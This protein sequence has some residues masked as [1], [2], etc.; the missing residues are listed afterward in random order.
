M[1]VAA[2]FGVSPHG[3]WAIGNLD[4]SLKRK[5]LFYFICQPFKRQISQPVVSCCVT[6]PTCFLNGKFRIEAF[7]FDKIK[8][9]TEIFVKKYLQGLETAQYLDVHL[10]FTMPRNILTST[11]VTPST[12]ALFWRSAFPRKCATYNYPDVFF[13]ETINCLSK[14]RK[15]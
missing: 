1:L 6:P 9:S 10:R 15:F 4:K 2:D 13:S 7:S 5:F 8:T 12:C 11:I 3:G 14:C